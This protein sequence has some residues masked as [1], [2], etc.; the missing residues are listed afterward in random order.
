VAWTYE[1]GRVESA[2]RR[3]S[4]Q[5]ADPLVDGLD[6]YLSET[7]VLD[8][9]AAL[10]A[11]GAYPTEILAEL[12][13]RGL[14]ELFMPDRANTP[15]LCRLTELLARRGGGLAI[16]VAVNALALLPVYLAGSDAQCAHVARRL[17]AGAS[18]ALLLTEL[19]HGSN[20]LRGEAAATATDGGFALTGDK[21]L[22][23]GGT[24]HDLLI[25]L[26]R[27]TPAG[28]DGDPFRAVGHFTLFMVDRGPTVEALPRWRTLPARS[29]D[30]SGVRFAGTPVP[31]D[32]VIDRVGSGFPLVQ[33]TLMVSHGGIA[34][35]AAGAA[36]AARALGHGYAAERDVYGAP[37]AML[38]A[39]AEHLARLR[40]LEVVV[41]ALAV[42]AACATNRFGPGAGYLAA[43]AK[44]SCCRLAEEAVAEG[45]AVLGARALLE[46]LPY[47]RLIRDTLLYGV[48]DGTS[49]LMLDTLSG[50][51][52][53]AGASGK[54]TLAATRELYATPPRPLREVGRRPW[55]PYTPS[56]AARSTDLAAAA[57]SEPVARIAS[58]AR[59]LAEAAVRT[60]AWRTD[61][62]YRFAAAKV[63]A[64]LEGLLAT[65]ELA[66]P[67]CRA[68]VGLPAA[69]DPADEVDARYALAWLGRRV[70]HGLDDLTAR[71][72]V[73]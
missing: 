41:G 64:Q 31:S 10:D 20:L 55:R 53:R 23:N 45:R 37:I 39:I 40:A 4:P 67:E 56:L 58:Y 48:F 70:E 3:L 27:T 5:P 59:T 25:A 35:L 6:K 30:I 15:E 42:K 18:A 13:A 8:R 36:T 17:R 69:A 21:Q 32:S 26:L 24:A 52:P 60:E 49:H 14:A 29:A 44:F 11:N 54:P 63:L 47:A 9:V 12:R 65:C 73:H 50:Y 28:G 57:G 72:G 34:A 22:I 43:A 33:K 61:Q 71:Q 38:G 2:V 19:D 16:T 66:L 51:V 1:H 62:A 7:D 68:A 46:E